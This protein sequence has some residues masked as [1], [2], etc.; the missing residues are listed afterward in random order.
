MQLH[1]KVGGNETGQARLNS[2]KIASGGMTCI[3]QAV[4]PAIAAVGNRFLL[5]KCLQQE[6][7]RWQSLQA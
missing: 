4:S 1:K 3:D 2:A 7:G 5:Q 6:L